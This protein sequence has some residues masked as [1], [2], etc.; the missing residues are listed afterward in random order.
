MFHG[1]I[2]TVMMQLKTTRDSTDIKK[3]KLLKTTY[4]LK[5]LEP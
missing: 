5:M 1:G 2:R 4:F 3:P